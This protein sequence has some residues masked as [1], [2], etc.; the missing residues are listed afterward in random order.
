MDKNLQMT[1]QTNITEL[2]AKKKE[3]VTLK[4]I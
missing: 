3:K 2:Y 4:I 1:M